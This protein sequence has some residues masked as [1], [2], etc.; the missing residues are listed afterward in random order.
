MK[1]LTQVPLPFIATLGFLLLLAGPTGRLLADA[2]S[3]AI[4]GDAGLWNSHTRGV[5]DSISKNGITDLI[6]P[7]DNLYIGTYELAWRPWT[8]FR[9][10]V[11]AIGNHHGG[12]DAE[13]KYFK[14][15]GEYYVQDIGTD[16]RFLVLNSDNTSTAS[17]QATWLDINLENSQAK[18]NFLVFHHPPFSIT[19]NHKWKER[20]KFHKN[21][22]PIILK[23][24]HKI[25]A[26]IVGHDHIASL[27]TLDELPMIVSGATH[28]FLNASPVNHVDRDVHVQT[29]WLFQP[30]AF[31]VRM[32]IDTEADDIQLNFVHAKTNQSQCSVGIKERK[33]QF[34]RNCAASISPKSSPIFR[35]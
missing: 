25:D 29:R 2:H 21:V 18:F 22:L 14:M 8:E 28:E 17:E 31:W 32:D 24:K 15:P 5:R 19:K 6:L 27:L 33:L 23:H 35:D 9:F 26:L 11:V 30:A 34:S 13:V 16:L 1:R 10:P 7:G 12:Y 3:F 20:E 4:I